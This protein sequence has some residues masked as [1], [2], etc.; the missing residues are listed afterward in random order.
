MNR[1]KV[2]KT[3]LRWKWALKPRGNRGKG[4]EER[5]KGIKRGNM[6]SQQKIL[7]TGKFNT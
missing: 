1:E 2:K 3:K 4:L 7:Q 5:K 6:K